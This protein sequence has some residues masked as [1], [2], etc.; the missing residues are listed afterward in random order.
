M[1]PL[2]SRSDLKFLLD[3]NVKSRVGKFLELD[4][5]DVVAA[6]KGFS[7]NKL[8]DISKSEG[9]VL[10]TNDSD[11]TNPIEFPKE[12]VFS[13]VLVAIPQDKPEAFMPA[14]S[15]LLTTRPKSDFEGFL[16]TLK[17]DGLEVSRIL[18]VSTL[19]SKGFRID[20]AE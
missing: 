11:F 7:D 17:E 5:F 10:V 12:K 14:F 9:R 19:K 20:V 8:A 18:S 1:P 2:T 4:G 15:R 3:E 16:I 13:V 6:P